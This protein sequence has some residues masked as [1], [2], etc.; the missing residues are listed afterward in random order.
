MWF[1]HFGKGKN[2]AGEAYHIGIFGKTGSGKSVLAKMIL[3]A[4]CKHKEMSVFILDPQGEFARDFRDGSE[5]RNIIRGLGRDAEVYSLQNL[6]L[7]GWDLFNKILVQ[8]GF[9]NK[10][11]IILDTNRLQ[12]AYQ[13]ERVL[14]ESI[15]DKKNYELLLN[16]YRR[17]YFDIVWSHLKDAFRGETLYEG[18]TWHSEVITDIANPPR[19]GNQRSRLFLIQFPDAPLTGA[20]SH[21][22]PQVQDVSSVISQLLDLIESLSHN[23]P[24]VVTGDHGYIYLGANPARYLWGSSPRK[25]ERSGGEYGENGI[26]VDGVKVAVGRLHVNVGPGSNTFIA[27]GGVSLTES[28]VPVATLGADATS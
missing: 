19:I 8:S 1:K 2:G 22:T 6:A 17:P 7:T 21:R 14:K 12:A 26:E 25:Q 10:L 18:K 27:H 5:V 4:Y 20:R 13:I 28:L 15:S 23:A 24:L 16:L 11:G 3:P 9:L